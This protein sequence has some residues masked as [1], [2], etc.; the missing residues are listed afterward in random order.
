[1]IRSF[2][3]SFSNRKPNAQPTTLLAINSIIHQREVTQLTPGITDKRD[4]AFTLNVIDTAGKSDLLD[5]QFRVRV[6]SIGSNGRWGGFSNSTTEYEG[7]VPANLVTRDY[8]RFVLNLGAL[9]VDADVFKAGA[10]LEVEII[11]T[12]SMGTRRIQKTIDWSGTVY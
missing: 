3:P 12:R 10:E 9:P 1:M 7:V 11:A 6:R 8:N 4:R 5:T 2:G